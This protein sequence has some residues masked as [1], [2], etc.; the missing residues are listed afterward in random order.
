MTDRPEVFSS[1]HRNP[2]GLDWQPA[3]TDSSSPITAA[4]ASTAHRAGR[5][6]RR[7]P[8]Q[9]LRLAAGVRSRPRPARG[10]GDALAAAPRAVG[11]TFASRPG[12]SWTGSYV[13]ETLRGRSLRRLTFSGDRVTGEQVMLTGTH[14]RRRAVV[15]RP[16][17]AL[18]VTTSNRDGRGRP[19]AGD[20]RIL[21]L[22]PPSS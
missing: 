8:G 17:G 22:V 3:A 1:G 13:V 18:Y 6:E 14:G 21:R 19:S 7:H 11:V 9:Q 2:Q 12:S 5:G 20:N 15:E 10:S 4:A 16:N